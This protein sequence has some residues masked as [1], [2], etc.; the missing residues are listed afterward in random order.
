[1]SREAGADDRLE[2]NRGASTGVA[3]QAFASFVQS[4]TKVAELLAMAYDCPL[5]GNDMV[6]EGLIDEKGRLEKHVVMRR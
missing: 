1:V 6:A 5:P 4:C 3:R 2:L